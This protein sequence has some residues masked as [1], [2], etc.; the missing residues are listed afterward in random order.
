MPPYVGSGR[1][2]L[3]AA[4]VALIIVTAVLYLA[5]EVLIPL[6]LAIVFGF[7]LAPA[8]R[9]L[10]SWRLH[11]VPA[12]LI[13]AAIALAI[14]I[15]VGWL[16]GNQFVSLVGKLPEYRDNI[17][18]KLSALRAPPKG[19]LG[20]AAEAIKDLESAATQRPREQQKP[21]PER[22]LPTTPLELIAE[23]GVPLLTLA[24]M[25]LAVVVL[26]VLMLLK[27][28]DLRDRVIRL[29]GEGRMNATTRAM[30]D[31]VQRVSRYVLMQLIVNAMYGVPLGVGL[32][33]IG[34]PNAPL[35]GLLAMVLRFIPYLGAWIAA[36][37]PIAL[38]FAISDG[39]TMVAWTIGVIVALELIVA[40]VIEPWIY[41][42][43]TGLSPLAIIAAV[44]FWT[45][46]WGPIGT[47]VATPLTVCVAAVGRHLP[48]FA[49]LNVILG[50]EPVL[51]PDMRFYQR[52]IA[53][54]H[55]EA[56]ELAQSYA[57]THGV[58]ALYD[59]VLIAAISLAK[60]DR[61]REQLSEG[62]ERLLLDNI[63]RL[64]EDLEAPAKGKAAAKSVCIVP[65]QDE[66]DYVAALLLARLLPFEPQVSSK[67]NEE[68]AC[69]VACISA[70]PP[71]A[72]SHAAYLAKRLRQRFPQLKIVV[73]MWSTE[74]NL[75]KA[76]VRFK[77]LGAD[78]VVSHLPEAVALL[79]RL[80]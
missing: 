49:F 11:R 31:A 63:R 23:L 45:W 24:S 39:W 50:I 55:E 40:Y 35:W 60:R 18:E 56:L 20:K 6:A 59:E 47:L 80:T 66:A 76:G 32:Y 42:G 54:D 34:V 28:E 8:V 61:S 44:I 68:L 65:A 52:M 5:R 10:E 64:A 15:G 29:A 30:E 75:D 48:Q 74:G 13:V 3:T 71:H 58:A 21:V 36:A 70:V 46:L 7:L 57:A 22:G 2:S 27:R 25:A 72:G 43:S 4:L 19:A 73:G 37:M 67:P 53:L 77:K 9:R 51:A 33:L 79:G 78:E 17:N 16:A 1:G 38:A 69:D 41:S 12:T 62:R 26:T 14:V